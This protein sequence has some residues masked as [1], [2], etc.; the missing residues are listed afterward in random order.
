MG[1]DPHQRSTEGMDNAPGAR[2]DSLMGSTSEAAKTANVEAARRSLT[3]ALDALRE[4]QAAQHQAERLV[5][6]ALES[7]G[8]A[9]P[10]STAPEVAVEEAPFLSVVKV[11]EILGVSQRQARQMVRDGTIPSFRLGQRVVVPRASLE[12]WEEEI[13]GQGLG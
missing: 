4:L 9:A 11:A 5:R 1:E 13:D 6:Q 10:S 8:Q 2:Q 7:V 12:G 3:A